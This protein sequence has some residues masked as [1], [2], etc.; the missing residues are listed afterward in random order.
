MMTS[1]IPVWERVGA[2][3]VPAIPFMPFV[4]W[5]GKK[6]CQK[7][8]L[9]RRDVRYL[10][11]VPRGS[12]DPL[13]P[14]GAFSPLSLSLQEKV[15]SPFTADNCPQLSSARPVLS[16]L[17]P[18]FPSLSWKTQWALSIC[19]LAV[20]TWRPQTWLSLAVLNQWEPLYRSGV[21]WTPGT[22]RHEANSWPV[23]SKVPV[24][25]MPSKLG[26]TATFSITSLL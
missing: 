23:R 19:E 16:A 6:R 5:K 2:W 9:P 13:E 15:K 12:R 11:V 24:C 18:F 4:S 22:G 14:D 25:L 7:G 17:F 8:P 3:W 1:P 26:E 10:T 21:D 20:W